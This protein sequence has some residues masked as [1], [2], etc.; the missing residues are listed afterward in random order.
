MSVK[1]SEQLN[2]VFTYSLQ[3]AER[4]GNAYVGPEH[5]LLGLIRNGSSHAAALMQEMGVDIKLLEKII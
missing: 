4:L 5:L 3:E 2:N 1:Y